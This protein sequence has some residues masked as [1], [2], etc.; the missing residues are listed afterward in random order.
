VAKL[1]G[2]T[3]TAKANASVRNPAVNSTNGYSNHRAALFSTS[4]VIALVRP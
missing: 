4:Y 3:T 1:G 2:D